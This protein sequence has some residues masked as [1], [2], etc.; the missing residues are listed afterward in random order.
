MNSV[1]IVDDGHIDPYPPV[2]YTGE[3]LSEWPNGQLKFHGC[4]IKGVP[5]GDQICYWENGQI[6]QIG[7][8]KD[9]QCIGLWKDY[10]EDGTLMLECEYLS[11][12]DFT[13]KWFDSDGIPTEA[14]FF[15][16][17]V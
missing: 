11:G 17:E 13:K 10:R 16:D 2:D 12:G 9:G 1:R 7:R 6:A 8:C 4:Y 14:T 5:E 15:K 3:W